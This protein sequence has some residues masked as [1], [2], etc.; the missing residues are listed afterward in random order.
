MKQ[1][2]LWDEYEAVMR[3]S[4]AGL[5]DRTGQGVLELT[6]RDR[7][8]FL[9]GMV[10]NDVASLV[11]G[12]ACRATFLDSTGH[13]LADLGVHARPGSLLVE[14][15]PRCLDR[16]HQTLEKYLIMEKVLIRDVSAAW[17]ILTVQ[18]G[19]AAALL[20]RTGGTPTDGFIAPARHSAPGGFD[21]WLPSSGRAG[22][23]EALVAAG[24]VPVNTE[25]MEVLRVEAGLAA[26]GH[27]LDETVLLP[28][29][30]LN[31]AVS[32]TKGCYIGQ[33][34][35]ARIAA[36]GH[37]NRA[38]RPILMAEDAAVPKPGDTLHLPEDAPEAGREIGRI[39]SGVE[40]PKFGGRALAFGYVRREHCAPGTPVT[41]HLRQPGGAVFA[42]NG[43][44]QAPQ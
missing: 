11:P 1:S 13:I 37:T 33:E 24:A 19:G 25:T 17:A 22:A 3:P 38:L 28:E 14:T 26:W 23:W 8:T 31:D 15:D 40:S 7:V 39:T 35:V 6:G 12:G 30:G 34:I 9:Q 21:L 18:G 36:R 42:T 44:M 2:P 27:E 41:V 10:S 5:A 20:A 32:Y 4:G 29:A 16:L 43:E